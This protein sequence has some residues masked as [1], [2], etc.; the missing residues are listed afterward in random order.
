MLT[1][2][3]FKG[4]V[5]GV[6]YIARSVGTVFDILQTF[7]QLEEDNDGNN[8]TSS[9]SDWH[10]PLFTLDEVSTIMFILKG[11]RRVPKKPVT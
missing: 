6:K 2:Y 7:P 9:S 10:L 1:L 3:L 8:G 4:F 5:E 11:A